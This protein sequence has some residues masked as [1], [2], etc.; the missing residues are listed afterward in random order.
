MIFISISRQKEFVL[1]AKM[2]VAVK[3]RE[4]KDLSVNKREIRDLFFSKLK[5]RPYVK[6]RPY[7]GVKALYHGYF[8]VTIRRDSGTLK[9][10]I[11]VFWFFVPILFLINFLYIRCI[12]Y[13][14]IRDQK[15]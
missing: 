4:I 2:S 13:V 6:K 7:I 15:G 1:F 3:P 14:N 8:E 12:N 5:R 9:L 11:K 10:I